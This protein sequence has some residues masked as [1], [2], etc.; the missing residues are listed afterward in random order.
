MSPQALIE[1]E[2]RGS[3]SV[4]HHAAQTWQPIGWGMVQDARAYPAYPEVTVPTLVVHGRQDESVPVSCSQEFASGRPT[5]V[6]ELLDSDHSLA[7]STDWIIRRS[8]RF[9]A[10][11]LT[12]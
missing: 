8:F 4:F 1:W 7:D 5:V 10:P 11:W 2:H 3:M 9:L 12:A 6:L